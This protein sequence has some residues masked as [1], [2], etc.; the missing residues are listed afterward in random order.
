VHNGPVSERSLVPSTQRRLTRAA[1]VVTIAGLALAGCSSGG[2]KSSSPSASGSPSPSTTVSVPPSQHL[3][4]QGTNLSFGDS[5]TV[6][7]EATKKA[8][9]VLKITVK[10]ARQGALSDFK[11][12]TLDDPY[13]R[14]A[15][16]YYVNVSV[17]NVGDGDVGG[18]PV[19]LWGVN[20]DNTLLPAVNFTT[21]FRTCPSKPLPDSF[22]PGASV[23]TCLV[24]LSPN[25]GTLDAVSYRP[26]Q[27]FNPI[28]W[29]GT[30]QSP[31]ATPTKKSKKTKRSKKG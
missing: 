1:A 6:V 15:N 4:A 18:V 7:F 26:S 13:K 14:K 24:Y 3:T 31:T 16:Y 11:A 12:F 28:Q 20:G 2:P 27:E 10:G 23:D 25:K 9:T 19:P 5:A 21:A 30:V 17:E 22:G 29:T 8:G